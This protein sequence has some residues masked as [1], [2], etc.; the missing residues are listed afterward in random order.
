MTRKP[1]VLPIPFSIDCTTDNNSMPC[2]I[3][4]KRVTSIKAINAFKRSKIIKANSISIP[5]ETMSI[6]IRV[7]LN[8]NEDTKNKRG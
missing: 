5:I 1:K 3:P 4:I 8:S 6:G 2:E 7:H